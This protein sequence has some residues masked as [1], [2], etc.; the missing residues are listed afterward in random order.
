MVK[1]AARKGAVLLNKNNT[2][3]LSS[4]SCVN[5][6]G[7]DVVVFRLGCLDAGKIIARYGIRVKEGIEK[8]SSLELNKEL[9]AAGDDYNSGAA[10]NEIHQI[11]LYPCSGTR[12]T[13]SLLRWRPLSFGNGCGTQ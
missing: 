4:S 3:P 9:Y 13:S 10:A 11:L 8:Y 6:F 2:L 5:V 1:Q 7:A 12:R